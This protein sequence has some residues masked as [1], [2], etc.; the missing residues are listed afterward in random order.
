MKKARRAEGLNFAKGKTFNVFRL[1]GRFR[2][3]MFKES[4]L[5]IH[6]PIKLHTLK[7]AEE[8]IK[9]GAESSNS[10]KN[11]ISPYKVRTIYINTRD[12]FILDLHGVKSAKEA[13][14]KVDY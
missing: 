6:P 13:E 2:S 10:R 1:I 4:I 12:P 11:L 7:D 3:I 9:E 14:N 8:P 5:I